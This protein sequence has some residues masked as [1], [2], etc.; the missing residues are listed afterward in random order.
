MNEE[1]VKQ[2][3][4]KINV[5]KRGDERAPHKPLL[6]LLALA[7]CRNNQR[8]IP[9]TEVDKELTELLMDFGPSRQLHHTE[10]PFWRLQNDGIWQLQHVDGIKTT[11][12][13][14]VSKK[15]LLK[16]NVVGGFKQEIYDIVYNDPNLLHKIAQELLENSFPTS[17]HEDILSAV[18]LE[19]EIE[20]VERSKRDPSFRKRVLI[21][22]EY[23]CSVCNFS[24]RLGNTLLA[25]EAAHIKWH[26][27]GGPDLETNGLALCSIHHKLFDRGAFTIS[28]SLTIEVSE[29]V[30]GANGCHEWLISFHG[31]PIKRPQNPNNSPK[32]SFLAWHTREVFRGPSRYMA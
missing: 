10:F 8:Y 13:G 16:R 2:L 12:S 14:D 24:V 6:L 20:N 32:I 29:Q 23:Q 25:L 9:F 28:D 5:W 31:K 18:G 19:Y 11:T 27:A 22:Y 21:S 30:N 26:Q 1:V 4:T 15:E 17:I 3:F 7:K